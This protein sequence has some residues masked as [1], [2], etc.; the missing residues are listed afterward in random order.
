MQHVEKV[1]PPHVR[2]HCNNMKLIAKGL[3]HKSKNELRTI[4]AEWLKRTLEGCTV[5]AVLIATVAFVTAYTVSKGHSTTDATLLIN[6][7]FFVVFMMIDVFSLSFALT[8]VVYFSQSSH[9][10]FD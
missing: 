5:V 4:L 6:K 8:S 1:T 10:H 3:F 9:Y 7:P 2:E